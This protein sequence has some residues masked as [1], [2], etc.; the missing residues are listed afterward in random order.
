MEVWHIWIMVAL[1]FVIIEIFTT[2]FAVLC[3]SLGAAV[4]ALIS[5]FGCSVEWQLAFFAI[6]TA[7]AFILVRPLLYRRCLGCKVVRYSGIEALLGRE[8]V[9]TERIDGYGG[10]VSVDGDSWRAITIANTVIDVGMKVCIRKV[11]STILVVEAI[12]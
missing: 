7:L 12:S 10:R 4:A 9:V 1:L 5:F 8:A 11:S 6:F 3:L 2:G